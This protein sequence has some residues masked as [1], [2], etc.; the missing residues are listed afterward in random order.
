MLR[1]TE[2]QAATN[3]SLTET[4]AP[5]PEPSSSSPQIIRLRGGPVSN[6]RITWGEE[7]VDNEGMGKKKSKICC[8]Y[9]KPRAFDESSSGESSSDESSDGENVEG[10]SGGEGKGKAARGVRKHRHHKC[11]HDHD[12]DREKG[13]GNGAENGDSSDNRNAYERQPGK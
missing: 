4:P 1:Q 2:P 3:G 9:H 12:R 8:I 7:V 6:R 11:N 13:E 10:G 5:P